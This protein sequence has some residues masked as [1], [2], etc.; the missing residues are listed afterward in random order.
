MTREQNARIAA[1]REDNYEEYLKLAANTKN[2]R[3]RT[4]LEKTGSIIEELGLK[5]CFPSLVPLP[6][7]TSRVIAAHK[8]AVV[9]GT[10]LQ[11]E[12]ASSCHI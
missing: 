8:S 6:L 2:Q 5:V 7:C 9:I 4:L 1:L 3:L 11:S 12:D 10:T